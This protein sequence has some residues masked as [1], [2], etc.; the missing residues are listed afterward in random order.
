MRAVHVDEGL[1]FHGERTVVRLHRAVP[2][3]EGRVNS[4]GG[5]L[6]ICRLRIFQDQQ[7]CLAN[8]TVMVAVGA[9]DAG[10][11]RNVDSKKALLSG[12]W[13]LFSAQGPCR[14]TSHNPYSGQNRSIGFSVN[15][16]ARLI[17]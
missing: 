6:R 5:N 1:S 12:S 3:S 11:D 13:D 9:D 17:V 16:E 4:S 8:R 10:P 14:A 2:L 7:I 15:R